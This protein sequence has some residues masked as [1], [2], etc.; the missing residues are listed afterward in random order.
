MAEKGKSGSPRNPSDKAKGPQSPAGGNAAGKGGAADAPKPAAKP[1][2]GAPAEGAASKPQDAKP[3]GNQG[4]DVKPAAAP[5][6]GKPAA[7]PAKAESEKPAEAK[8]ASAAAASGASKA[9]PA[10]ADAPKSEPAK[11]AATAAASASSSASVADKPKAAEPA[12][13]A[14]APEKPKPAP[15]K[16]ADHAEEEIHEEVE[17][18]SLSSVLLTW[19]VIFFIGAA[20]ALWGGPKIAPNLPEFAQPLAKYLT[21]GANENDAELAA[22]RDNVNESAAALEALRARLDAAEAALG[23]NAAAISETASLVSAEPEEPLAAASDLAALEDSLEARLGA[24]AGELENDEAVAALE[25]RIAA[26]ENAGPAEALLSRIDALETAD[27]AASGDDEA[28]SS[29]RSEIAALRESGDAIAALA[30]KDALSAGLAGLK[31]E[32]GAVR[33]EIAAL[34][35]GMEGA[36]STLAGETGGEIEA[37]EARLAALESGEAATASARTEAEEIRRAANLDAAQVK[38]GK[39]LETGAPFTAALNEAVSLS[40]V[41]AP[42]ALTG[43]ADS[44]V[45]PASALLGSFQREARRG[46][47][48]AQEAEAGNGV[49][50]KLFAQVVGRIGG[51]P[52]TETEGDD[53]GAVLS[54]IEARLKDGQ[55]ADA[56]KEAATLPPA[57]AEAMAGW[58]AELEAAAA[59][60]T[61]FDEWRAT[62]AVN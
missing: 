49:G 36:V 62:P 10:K 35:D 20:A 48:A 32:I 33:G 14:P 26:L 7:A 37:L 1:A 27:A 58:L 21:P 4:N 30:S 34:N 40:G 24:L 60:R 45:T 17:R 18:R 19:I 28:L 16:A 59:A 25:A 3:Q 6:G 13:P 47:A 8:A 57:S 38:I 31:D 23:E 51:R 9:E 54:R 29:I 56:A 12:K 55:V 46:Y 43:F 15:A 44:G 41:P 50:E 42:E 5:A 11:P 53:A 2:A 22:L 52:V 61:G 39:A